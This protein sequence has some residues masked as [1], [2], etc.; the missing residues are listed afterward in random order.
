MYNLNKFYVKYI[1]VKERAEFYSYKS[2]LYANL[3][4]FVTLFLSCNS[5]L[6]IIV[7]IL[8]FIVNFAFKIR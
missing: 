7:S 2:T 3:C 1:H 6:V 4:Y 8:L 5:I